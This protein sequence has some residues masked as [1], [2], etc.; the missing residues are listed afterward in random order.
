MTV[1]AA[2]NKAE[3]AM[4]RHDKSPRM[5]GEARLEFHDGEFRVMV[6]GAFVRC[7]VTGQAIALEDVK[8]WDVDHQEAYLSPLEKLIRMGLLD[9]A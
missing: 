3:A 6:P 7:A 8:Y 4:N 5:D 1:S 2:I 9:G